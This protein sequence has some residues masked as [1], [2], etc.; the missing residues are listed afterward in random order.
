MRFW[1]VLRW[2]LRDLR[3]RWLQ[4]VAIA[5][6]IAV[7]TGVY[8]GLGSTSAWRRTS[9]DASYAALGMYDL[10][11]KA[12]EGLDAAEGDMLAIADTIDDRA[13][14]TATEERLVVA[15]QV[16]ASTAEQTILVPGRV[17]GV[18]TRAGG[19]H[20]NDVWVAR[21]DGRRFDDGEGAVVLEQHFASFYDLPATGAI[22]VEGQT[23]PYVGTGLSPEYFMILTDDGGLF[24]EA[25]FAAV[26]APLRTAQQL[27]ARPGRVNDLV[28]RVRSGTDPATIA[29]E[30]RDAF[31]GS[32]LAVTVME[33]NDDDAY[34]MLYADIDSD[35]QFWNV[36]AGLIL[37]GAAFGAFNLTSR[38][39]EAERRQIGI[40]M[41]LG[42]SPA[43]LAIRPLLVGVE[44][45]LVGA[46]LGVGMGWIVTAAIRPVY[47]SM[48]P[49]PIWQTPL[50]LSMFAKAALLGFA[51]P[52]LATAWPVW[53]AVRVAP[54]DAIATTHHTARG[55]L[56]T[57]LRR[58]HHPRGVF[59]RMPIG[60]VLRAPRR[61]LLT[62][63]GIGAAVTALLATLGMM[64][65]FMSTLDRSDREV[66]ADHPDRVVVMLKEFAP[67]DGTVVAGVRADPTVG[68]AQPVLHLGARLTA[69]AHEPIDLLLDVIDLDGE[70][71]SP[72]IVRGSIPAD[73]SG[74]VISAEAASDLGIAAGDSISLEHPTF[75]NGGF[76]LA[77]TELRVAGVQPSPFRFTAY[78]DR[79]QLALLGL[80]DVANQLYVVPASSKTP[81]DV[82]RA[83]F[84]EPDVAWAL[85][86]SASTRMVKDTLDEFVAVFRILEAFMFLL[87][88]LIA[89]NATSISV[90]ERA[91]EHA[92]LFA[93]G[94]PLR[95]V[96]RMNVVE[97]VLIGL[98]GTL[99][100]VVAG[101]G[102]V[103]WIT[104]ELVANT[105]PEIGIDTTISFQTVLTATLMG[106]VAV[107]IAPLLSIR[108]LRGM[109]VPGTLRIVE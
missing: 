34:R 93:F 44:I 53:R 23:V 2:S 81:A 90:D 71:W 104:Q 3:R 36:F 30:L 70:V 74:I 38:M 107:G 22:D 12:S 59:A 11:V 106:T 62:A 17:I 67:A 29:N 66:L 16:D 49:L 64:D 7:G 60:N 28:V 91:R 48:L 4:V 18:D 99:V 20:I 21:G 101:F 14:M 31:A 57:L 27:T 69:S 75:R 55:G 54:V 84:T 94:L 51:L 65:S 1:F 86:V 10:R 9:N 103:R 68:L 47:T 95:R 58:F 88:M 8:A 80:P 89:Y 26:F 35:Q 100:G 46:M 40:G 85:P 13:A 50:Q 42:A 52:V 33:R 98:L 105:M 24:A 83:L 82:Q 32:G 56:S 76:E 78:I 92:T 97:N 108:R 77:A 19:P 15:T 25:N 109:D 39:V 79:S 41:A 43:R 102:V 6:I 87:A 96:V 63:F 72:T 61:T 5:L 37:L 73:R 45:A